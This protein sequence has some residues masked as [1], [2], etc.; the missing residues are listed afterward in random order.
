MYHDLTIEF[1]EVYI[2]I[3]YNIYINKNI[4][5]Y[6]QNIYLTTSNSCHGS[7]AYIL[8][9]FICIRSETKGEKNINKLKV[10]LPVCNSQF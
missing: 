4:Y 2:Y 7:V 3:I 10:C 6:M 8:L 1:Y 5:I 9:L